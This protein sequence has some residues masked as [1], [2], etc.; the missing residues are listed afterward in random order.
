MGLQSEGG[1][2]PGSTEVKA[3]GKKPTEP[4]YHYSQ[5]WI[6]DSKLL[7]SFVILL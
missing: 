7:N 4:T 6:H 2:E 3:R 5:N 1:F